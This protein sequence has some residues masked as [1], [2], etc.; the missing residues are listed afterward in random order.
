MF[1]LEIRVRPNS[2]KNN[3]GGSVGDPPRL[4]VRVQAPAVDGKANGAVLKELANAFDAEAR[5]FSIVH[6]E[7]ARDERIV[8]KGDEETLRIRL[9]ELLGEPTLL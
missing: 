7:V 5:D 3:V 8:V 1:I 2:K 6:G 9:E 4:V